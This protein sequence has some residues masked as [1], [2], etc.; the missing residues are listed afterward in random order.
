M[1]RFEDYLDLAA[2]CMANAGRIADARYRSI[3]I[4]MAATWC[5]L[6]QER[7]EEAGE[8]RKRLEE[9]AGA[10][11]ELARSVSHLGQRVEAFEERRPN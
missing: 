10:I 5:K 2:Q 7:L 6:A 11:S 3:L 4:D 9:L 1:S 8:G